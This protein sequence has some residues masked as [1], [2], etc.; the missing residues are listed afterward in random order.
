MTNDVL[1]K[2]AKINYELELQ[3]VRIKKEQVKLACLYAERAKIHLD[4]TINT[5]KEEKQ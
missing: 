2:L 5:C 4:D 1:I 3:E